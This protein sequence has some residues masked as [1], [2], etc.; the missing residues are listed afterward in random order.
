MKLIDAEAENNEY[1]SIPKAEE[2]P[3]V[4]TSSTSKF[5]YHPYSEEE[6]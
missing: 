5:Y 3:R 2:A 6:K 1:G 4:A